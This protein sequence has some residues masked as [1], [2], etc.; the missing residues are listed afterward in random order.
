MI[1]VNV[2]VSEVNARGNVWES[3]L[4]S[5]FYS[6]ISSRWDSDSL[7]RGCNIAGSGQGK[8]RGLFFSLKMLP[9]LIT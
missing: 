2:F 6:L 7:E 8:F 1:L 3:M 9:V 5:S 4:G